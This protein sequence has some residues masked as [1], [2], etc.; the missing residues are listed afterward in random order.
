MMANTELKIMKEQI[1]SEFKKKS[2]GDNPL[3]YKL[4]PTKSIAARS[5]VWSKFQ[6][7][8]KRDGD[9]V[10]VGKSE[11]VACVSCKT[12]Y[13]YTPSLGTSTITQHTCPSE[14]V[15]SMREFCTKSKPFTGENKR[16]TTALVDLCAEDL[17]LFA[18]VQGK[19][20]QK[21]VQVILDIAIAH[22]KRLDAKELLPDETTIKRNTS[23]RDV[24]GRD[25]LKKILHDHF[26]IGLYAGFTFDLWTDDIRKVAYMSIIVHYISEKFELNAR[27]LHVKP[28][29]DAS[30]TTIMV[31]DEFREGL[32]T[33]DL[34]DFD[35][36]QFI[37][38]SDSGSNCSGADGVRSLYDWHPCY[39]H[40]IATVLTTILNKTTVMRN[41]VRSAPFYKYHDHAPRIYTLIDAVKGLITFFKQTNLQGKLTKTL[42]QENVTRWNSLLRCLLSVQDM[43]DEVIVLMTE[44]NKL[45]KVVNI[46]KD[47]LKE[48]ITFLE[49]FQKATLALEKFKEPTLHLILASHHPK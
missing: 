33:F 48:L 16:V 28:V 25:K 19:G 10:K 45:H 39:D 14:V 2:S 46:D 11:F 47:L 34:N 20:F 4:K 36:A 29:R 38:V 44:R 7:V 40:K 12:V 1:Q 17:R 18:I 41:G 31:S 27:N 30:H 43:L 32:E 6:G 9:K 22:N 24:K 13:S 15:G 35:A 37:V 42:K 8:Y 3:I 21:F 23:D 49:E 5:S 26:S